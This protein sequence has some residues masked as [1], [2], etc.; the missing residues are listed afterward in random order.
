MRLACIRFAT[1]AFPSKMLAL[2][3]ESTCL[4]VHC[5]EHEHILSKRRSRLRG[6]GASE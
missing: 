4:L 5:L 2:S 6:E 1:S 3:G